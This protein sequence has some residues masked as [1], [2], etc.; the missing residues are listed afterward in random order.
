[1]TIFDLD[2]SYY[3]KLE[4]KFQKMLNYCNRRCLSNCFY[5]VSLIKNH[6]IRFAN[7]VAFKHAM[8]FIDELFDKKRTIEKNLLK[9]KWRKEFQL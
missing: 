1:M 9:K 4:S 7:D 5:Q 3:K 6:P 2:L 8:P